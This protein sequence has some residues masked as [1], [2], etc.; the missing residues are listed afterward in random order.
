MYY[1]RKIFLGLF[2][3]LSISVVAFVMVRQM[4]GD[5]AVLI[6]NQNRETEA[7][8]ELV[9]SIREEYGFDRPLPEQYWQIGRAHV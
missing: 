5:P 8:P 1:L 2:Y 3:L 9:E 7:P 4:P 6:A